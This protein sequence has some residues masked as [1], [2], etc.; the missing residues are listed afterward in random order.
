MLTG[1]G[2]SNPQA[3]LSHLQRHAC[4]AYCRWSQKELEALGAC[5]V[6]PLQHSAL[7]Q[8]TQDA[9]LHNS[10]LGAETTPLGSTQTNTSAPSGGTQLP[11]PPTANQRLYKTYNQPARTTDPTPAQARHSNAKEQ[12]ALPLREPLS[13]LRCPW[14]SPT[15]EVEPQAEDPPCPITHALDQ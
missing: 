7:A 11:T 9:M 2:C 14:A 1:L 13:P 4:V 10:A 8:V 6:P 5:F 15:S 3:S 12:P